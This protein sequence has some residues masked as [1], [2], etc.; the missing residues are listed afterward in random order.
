MTATINK[1]DR[2]AEAAVNKSSHQF[3][4]VNTRQI[5][6]QAD[7]AEQEP[8]RPITTVQKANISTTQQAYYKPGQIDYER[9]P[10]SLQ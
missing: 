10:F 6:P 2:L 1:P 9:N 8:G 7:Q 4:V 5:C 3:R